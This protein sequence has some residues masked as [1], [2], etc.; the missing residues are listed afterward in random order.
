MQQVKGVEKEFNITELPTFIFFKGGKEFN[1]VVGA[2]KS[3]I[4][5]LE[6][7]VANYNCVQPDYIPDLE[8]KTNDA[9]TD[10]D[11]DDMIGKRFGIC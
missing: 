1:R 10:K 8:K 9:F 11:F 2:S 5:E 4:T 6:T 7:L 3:K